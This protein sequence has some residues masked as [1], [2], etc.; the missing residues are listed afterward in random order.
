MLIFIIFF[1]KKNKFKIENIINKIPNNNENKSNKVKL[2]NI[3][4]FPL[5][6]TNKHNKI[7][8]TYSSILH[9]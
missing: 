8:Y 1:L 4:N 9:F 3:L 6:K 2:R 5:K 7:N